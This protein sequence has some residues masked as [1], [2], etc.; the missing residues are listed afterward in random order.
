MVLSVWAKG[1]AV[2]LHEVCRHRANPAPHARGARTTDPAARAA[3]PLG[4]RVRLR[5]GA[6][7][8]T[9]QVR[10]VP[11]WRTPAPEAARDRA[12]RDRARTQ[13][14]TKAM[15]ATSASP[16]PRAAGT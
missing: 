8:G 5:A 13:A 15:A 14:A 2:P 4:H 9:P 3:L 16:S 1:H 10:R 6:T 11:A 7:H 12:P